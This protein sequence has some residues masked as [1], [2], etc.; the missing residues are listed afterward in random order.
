MT[1]K[2]VYAQECRIQEGSDDVF[3]TGFPA[4]GTKFL[5]LMKA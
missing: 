2:V 4:G 1:V 5:V 3:M